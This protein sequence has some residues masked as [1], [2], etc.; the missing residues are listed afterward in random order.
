MLQAGLSRVS[1]VGESRMELV[2]AGRASQSVQ[3]PQESSQTWQEATEKGL[4]WDGL[5]LLCWGYGLFLSLAG[6]PRTSKPVQTH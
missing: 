4:A 5:F 1:A 2:T 3:N 6:R